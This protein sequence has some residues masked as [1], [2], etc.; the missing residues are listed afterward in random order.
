MLADPARLAVDPGRSGNGEAG[1]S[2][3]DGADGSMAQFVGPCVNMLQSRYYFIPL[4]L[5]KQM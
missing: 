5:N 2:R 4:D 1:T 3:R